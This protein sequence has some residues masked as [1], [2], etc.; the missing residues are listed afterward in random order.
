MTWPETGKE[1]EAWT[2]FLEGEAASLAGAWE[3]LSEQ[4]L[5]PGLTGR[6][7]ARLRSEGLVQEEVRRVDWRGRWASLAG[8]AAAVA[9]VAG[10]GLW[11]GPV[12]GLGAGPGNP[13]GTDWASGLEL[14][15]QF[16]SPGEELE[17]RM[18]RLFELIP[19]E[20]EPGGADESRRLRERLDRLSQELEVF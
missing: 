4:E 9:L 18:Q 13:A 3:R 5:P 10:L 7:L 15:E 8:I 1:R 14:G 6:T 19:E 2:S 16:Q 17:V 12:P 11:N 20:V